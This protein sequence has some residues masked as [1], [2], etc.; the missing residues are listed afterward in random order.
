MLIRLTPLLPC[1]AK[2]CSSAGD[3]RQLIELVKIVVDLGHKP[4][5]EIDVETLP[6]SLGSVGASGQDQVRSLLAMGM[7]RNT[8]HCEG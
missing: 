6:L 3:E 2:E 5:G 7:D 1:I 4:T 8:R